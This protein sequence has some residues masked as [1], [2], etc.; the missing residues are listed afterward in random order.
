MRPSN[1]Y[2]ALHRCQTLGQSYAIVTVM[3]VAG[4][5]PREA[6]T[7][8]I[9]TGD[10]Q[11]DTIGGGHLEYQA[12]AK[13]RELLADG[14]Q[15]QHIE[16]YP[17]SSKLGQCCGGAMKVFIEVHVTHT[18]TLAIFGGGHVAQALIPIV[19]QLPLQIRWIDSR[20]ECFD[21]VEV[22]D[23]VDCII[24]DDPVAEMAD[25]P[26]NSWA[27]ILTH[28]H[29]LDYELVE[30]ALKKSQ[31]DFLG[32]IGSETKAKR[33]RTRLASR[34][35]SE[36]QIAHMVSPIGERNV[37]GKRPIEVAVAISAQIIQRL[38]TPGNNTALQPNQKLSSEVQ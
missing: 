29:Q 24:D 37:P 12:V 5:T 4:S 16:S 34:D 1:W 26:P 9:V 13:A 35:F 21:A 31:C 10:S 33:F 27:V 38:N 15:I 32:M 6:G 22:P 28:N 20:S 2:D 18:Q 14:N 3:T 30:C 36:Q 17:L 11:Y 8:M 19:S 25:L 23:N 7:K